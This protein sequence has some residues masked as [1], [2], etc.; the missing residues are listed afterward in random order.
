MATG[1]RINRNTGPRVA[2]R[3][4]ILALV[5]LYTIMLAAVLA[6]FFYQPALAANAATLFGDGPIVTD[7]TVLDISSGRVPVDGDLTPED[8]GTDWFSFTAE[9]GQNYIIELEGTLDFIE[10]DRA[11]YNGHLV[12][13]EGRL[14]DPSILEIV[15][16]NL[17]AILVNYLQN[18][19]E[20]RRPAV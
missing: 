17:L 20:R 11:L 8:D 7:H 14:S 9:G 18:A 13:A 4:A 10:S 5:A 16:Q 12:N 19:R 3:A 15:D 1:H 6:G 2:R